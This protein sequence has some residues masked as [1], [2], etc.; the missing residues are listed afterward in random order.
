VAAHVW[1]G[2]GQIS[3]VWVAAGPGLSQGGKY[4]TNITTMEISVTVPDEVV[5]ALN[6]VAAVHG[7]G[8]SDAAQRAFLTGLL[9][10]V[11]EAEAATK[12]GRFEDDQARDISEG[13]GEDDFPRYTDSGEPSISPEFQRP[14]RR[15]GSKRFGYHGSAVVC[16]DCREDAGQEYRQSP[17]G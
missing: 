7:L 10:L 6:L 15:C 5:Q 13:G 4:S 9:K 2:A 12:V 8:R 3:G 17:P 11:S 14:C 1:K 16:L